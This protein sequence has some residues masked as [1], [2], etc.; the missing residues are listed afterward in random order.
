MGD[1]AIKAGSRNSNRSRHYGITSG[2]DDSVVA[3]G[4]TSSDGGSTSMECSL[5]ASLC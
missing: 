2:S 5:D 3:A 1:T 4:I